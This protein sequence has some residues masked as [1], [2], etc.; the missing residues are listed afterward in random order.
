MT[1]VAFISVRK[2]KVQSPD[3]GTQPCT[4]MVYRG[5]MTIGCFGVQQVR[6]V[7]GMEKQACLRLFLFVAAFEA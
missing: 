4:S 2:R 6:E 7:K 3:E 1:L 5:M